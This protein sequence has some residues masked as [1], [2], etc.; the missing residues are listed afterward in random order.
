MKNIL[1]SL[2]F[3]NINPS[4]QCFSKGSEYEAF[5]QALC[6]AEEAL[7]C[8]L[9]PDQRLVYDRYTLVQCELQTLSNQEAFIDGFKLGAQLLLEALSPCADR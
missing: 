3:G 2:Y 7:L 9:T 5:I 6:K 1:E 8:D 4:E